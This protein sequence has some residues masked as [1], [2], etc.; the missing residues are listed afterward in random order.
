MNRA[1]MSDE[2]T[3]DLLIHED[4]RLHAMLGKT[5]IEFSETTHPLVTNNMKYLVA[6]S[7]LRLYLTELESAI[8]AEDAK[9]YRLYVLLGEIEKKR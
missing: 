3:C 6:A 4:K 1:E 7:S 8:A 9:L 5:L 2:Q